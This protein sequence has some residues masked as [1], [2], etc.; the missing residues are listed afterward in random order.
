MAYIPRLIEETLTA[1]LARSGAVLVRGPKWCGKTSTCEQFA[2]STLRMRDPDAYASNMEAANVRPSLLL[3]GDR[4]RL[5]DEWQVAPVLWDAVIN[6]VDVSG[7]EPGQFLLTGSATPVNF[8]KDDETKPKH[9]GTGR[10]ARVDMDTFSLEESADSSKEVSLAALFG[11]AQAVEGASDITVERYA[12]LIC[13]GGWPAPI[14]RKSLN[15]A[16]ASDYID[17][18]CDADISEA[19]DSALDP[20]RAHA[21]L[22]S[23]ARNSSQEASVSTLLADVRSVGVAMSEPTL[24]VYLNALKRLFVVENLKAWAP[25]L[26]S[27]TPL[28]SS[29]TWHLCDPSLAAAALEANPDALLSDLVTMGYLFESLCIRD[30]RI[31]ARTL[32][33]RIFHYRDKTGLEADAIVRLNNGSWG[34][35]EVKLGGEQRIEEGAQHLLALAKKVDSKASGSPRFLMVLTGGRYAYTRPDGVHVVPLGCLAH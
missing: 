18:L 4:P 5:I 26:R 35:V 13:A 27:R 10:I 6:E 20:D 33:G 29:E 9:T 24:R 31:Y 32:D 30:L 22:R 23:I 12:E 1:K 14:A 19:S 21:L 2:K 34:A 11:G 15:T 16:I 17:S 28:R 8:A 3:R 25:A 7:G